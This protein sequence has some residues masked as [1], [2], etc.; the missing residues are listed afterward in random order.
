MSSPRQLES[1]GFAPISTELYAANN[2]RVRAAVATATGVR[3]TAS[4]QDMSFLD[5]ASYQ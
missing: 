4:L 1:R 5:E 3:Q 2:P